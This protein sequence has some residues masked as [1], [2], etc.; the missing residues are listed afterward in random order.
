ML[1]WFL[2]NMAAFRPS[3][4]QKLARG[5]SEEGRG[6]LRAILWRLPWTRPEVSNGTR[7]LE[8]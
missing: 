8:L 7:L 2:L 5:G 3:Q 6:R 1:F 4:I